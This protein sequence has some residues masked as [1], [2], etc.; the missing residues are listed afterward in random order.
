MTKDEL[1]SLVGGCSWSCS[2][3]PMFI[4]PP[5]TALIG[6]M[7]LMALASLTR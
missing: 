1:D 7:I 4:V 3:C 5:I 6:L 2:L